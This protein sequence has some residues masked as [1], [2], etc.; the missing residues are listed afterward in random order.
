MIK[1]ENSRGYIAG[2]GVK[3]SAQPTGALG[4]TGPLL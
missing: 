1:F 2:L 4:E 3:D